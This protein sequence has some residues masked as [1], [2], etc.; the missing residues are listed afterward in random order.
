[1]Q[2]PPS[3]PLCRLF[4]SA[5]YTCSTWRN[6][7]LGL[8]LQTLNQYP[9]NNSGVQHFIFILFYFYFFVFF[10]FSQPGERKKRKRRCQFPKVQR[11][12]MGKILCP[13]PHIA[14]EQI[15]NLKSP[16]LENR[17]QQ[18]AKL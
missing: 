4:S 7:V 6:T 5:M 18:I 3:V 12:F 17:F 14:R 16:Y 9:H 15:F 10:E 11:L 1:M 13:S 2:M 8:G